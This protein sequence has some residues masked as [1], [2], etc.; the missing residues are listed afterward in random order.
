MG[1]LL[2]PASQ[3]IRLRVCLTKRHV[4]KLRLPFL[5]FQEARFDTVLDDKFNRSDGTRLAK[6]MLSES[7]TS[8]EAKIATHY[9]VDGL[10]LDGWVPVAE[11]SG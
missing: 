2:H 4:C 10:V 9:S 7:Q 1:E 11:R 6:A 5:D 3:Y 8:D